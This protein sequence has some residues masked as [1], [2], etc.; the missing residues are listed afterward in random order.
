M[1]QTH[2]SQQPIQ[3]ERDQAVDFAHYI[4]IFK[5]RIFYFAIP[6]VLLLVIGFLISAIQRPI[7]RAEGRLLVEPPAIPIDLVEPTVTA[8]ATE[9]IKVIEQRITSRDNLLSTIKKFGLFPSEQ[10]WMS[11]TELLDLMRGRVEIQLVDLDAELSEGKGKDAKKSPTAP[12]PISKNPAIAFTISFDYENPELAM[13]VAND[14]LT[15]VL[16]E[17]VRAR[18]NRAAEIT[19]FLGRE[20]KRL[21]GELDSVNAQISEAKRAA[22]IAEVTRAGN[23]NQ[24]VSEKL[25][26]QM[27][28]LAALKADLIQRASVYSEGHPVVKVLKKRIA[29]L[30]D[31]I[32]QAPKMD[33]ALSQAG[34]NIE[35]LEQQ[36]T[37]IEKNLDDASKK[38]IAARLGE[39]MERNQQSEPLLVIEQP[40]LPQQPVRP[41]R[42]KLFAISFALATMTGI[43]VV[44]L[45]E[46]LDKSIRGSRQLAGVVDAHLVI[47]IPYISTTKE[48]LRRK[49]RI[50]VLWATL[51]AALITGLAVALYIGITIDFSWFDRP[52]IESLTRLTK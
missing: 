35:V 13:K 6:F 49:R 42:L 10:R 31:E 26:S 44:F 29:A 33:P 46:M 3:S 19:Q 2:G 38:L 30:E 23:S 32:S 43:G 25:K 45:V 36:Q 15:S 47:A 17:D 9:R 16:N 34:T 50:V 5:R 1:L 14:F 7:Y 51:T 27:T 12:R 39:S 37:S 22:E 11:G 40:S 48:I 41:K 52:W 8:P 18:S 20:V 4:G 24:G 21:Q 28:M